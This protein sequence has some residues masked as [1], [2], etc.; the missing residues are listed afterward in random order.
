MNANDLDINGI[1]QNP[2]CF[3]CY[4]ARLFSVWKENLRKGRG[5]GRGNSSLLEYGD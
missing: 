5:R 4:S 2:D 1:S 3:D